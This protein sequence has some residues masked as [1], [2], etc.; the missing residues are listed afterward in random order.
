MLSLGR[1]FHSAINREQIRWLCWNVLRC[2]KLTNEWRKVVYRNICYYT[3]VAKKVCWKNIWFPVKLICYKK[4]QWWKNTKSYGN[5]N[6][7][8]DTIILLIANEYSQVASKSKTLLGL[9]QVLTSAWANAFQTEA[10]QN[11]L[12]APAKASM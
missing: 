5:P 7:V 12:T 3:E 11:W 6:I 1:N 9:L 4:G 8:T 2:F 10:H